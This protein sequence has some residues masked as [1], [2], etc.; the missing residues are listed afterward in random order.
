MLCFVSSLF[1]QRIT[2]V[3]YNYNVDNS[4]IVYTALH[5]IAICWVY[6]YVFDASILEFTNHFVKRMNIIW[7]RKEILPMNW[8]DK[9]LKIKQNIKCDTNIF[10]WSLFLPKIRQFRRTKFG[11]EITKE[12]KI[13]LPHFR[14]MFTAAHTALKASHI[15]EMFNVM[16]IPCEWTN[17]KKRSQERKTYKINDHVNTCTHTLCATQC[18]YIDYVCV[19]IQIHP[20]I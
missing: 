3:Q 12:K 17:G 2:S 6:F 13:H 9:T 20:V 8:R 5:C 14:W 7:R 18:V 11:Y 1:V 19:E 4:R 10:C 16:I 15:F